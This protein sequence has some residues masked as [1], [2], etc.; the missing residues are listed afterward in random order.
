MLFTLH[1]PNAIFMI[2][3]GLVL[4]SG[5]GGGHEHSHGGGTSHGHSHG[6]K[7]HSHNHNEVLGKHL[8]WFEYTKK[9]KSSCSEMFEVKAFL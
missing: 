2:Q 1:F 6:A 5:G 7:K 4:F 8:K 3:F 9:T